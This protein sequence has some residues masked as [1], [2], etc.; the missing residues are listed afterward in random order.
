MPNRFRNPTMRAQYDILVKAYNDK[1]VHLFHKDGS[2]KRGSSI[3]T[4]FW[5]GFNDTPTNWCRESKTWVAY[6]CFRAGQD[7]AEM[8]FDKVIAPYMK[9]YREEIRKGR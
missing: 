8:E 2:Q 5:K 7:M 3:A 1:S 9:M 6:A 4:Y